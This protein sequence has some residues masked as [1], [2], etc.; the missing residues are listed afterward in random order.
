MSIVRKTLFERA[1]EPIANVRHKTVLERATEPIANLAHR[2][3]LERASGTFQESTRDEW[4]R[5]GLA[6]TGGF[7]V[8]SVASAITGAYRRRREGG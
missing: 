7:V 5:K 3:V 2:S 4:V 6:T 1:T 8:V